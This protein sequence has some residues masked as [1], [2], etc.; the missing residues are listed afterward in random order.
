MQWRMLEIEATEQNVLFPIP[1]TQWCVASGSRVTG[2][3]GNPTTLG[4]N[5]AFH[6]IATLTHVAVFSIEAQEYYLF[7]AGV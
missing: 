3:G 5:A 6:Q 7:T 1:F 4:A 2:T